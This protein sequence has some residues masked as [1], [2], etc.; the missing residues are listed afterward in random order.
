MLEWMPDAT[1][2]E[3]MADALTLH[4][5]GAQIKLKQHRKWT[6]MCIGY[7]TRGEPEGAKLATGADFPI[8]FASP[9]RDENNRI[10][11]ELKT[12]VSYEGSLRFLLL[13]K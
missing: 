3:D 7:N 11:H 13:C 12:G 1:E 9:D 4:D 5:L 6:W 2:D 8:S 10:L